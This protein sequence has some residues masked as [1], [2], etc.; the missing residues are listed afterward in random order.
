MDFQPMG[1]FEAK[2]AINNLKDTTE[3]GKEIIRIR[4]LNGN[5]NADVATLFDPRDVTLLLAVLLWQRKIGKE[6]VPCS[7]L[8]ERMIDQDARHI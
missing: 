2:Y 3:R 1:M 5:S 8:Y 6:F 4:T 7:P